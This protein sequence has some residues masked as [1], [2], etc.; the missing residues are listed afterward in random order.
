MGAVALAIL[1]AGQCV[2][3]ITGPAMSVLVMTGRERVRLA[4]VAGVTPVC[5][6]LNLIL[7]PWAGLA[8]AAIATALIWSLQSLLACAAVLRTHG[9]W[10]VGNPFRRDSPAPSTTAD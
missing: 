10:L 8:G 4:I 6:A 3:A 1:I 2:H 9:F 5:L 7:I